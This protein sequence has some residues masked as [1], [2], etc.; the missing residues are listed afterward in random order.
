MS[1]PLIVI[2]SGAPFEGVRR[3]ARGLS[4]SLA[5][6]VKVLFVDPT[7]SP[8]AGSRSVSLRPTLSRPAPNLFHLGAVTVPGHTRMG[9]RSVAKSAVVRGVRSAIS[10]IGVGS[11]TAVF[12]QTPRVNLLGQFDEDISIYWATDS[13]VD[14]FALMGVDR[15]SLA[16]AEMAS[17]AKADLVIAVTESLASLWSEQGKRVA[18]VRNGVDVTMEPTRVSPIPDD[19]TLTRPIAGVVGT[20]SNRLDFGMLGAVSDAGAS[21]LLIG[22]ASFRTDRSA[23]DALCMRPNVLWLGPK[24]HSDLGR[25]YQHMDV[26]LVPYTLSD[27]NRVSAPL[28]PLEYLAAGLPVVSTRLAGV[29]AIDSPDIAFASDSAEFVAATER[30]IEVSNDVGFVARRRRHVLDWSWDRRA[31][32]VLRILS[33]DTIS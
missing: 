12:L 23:F 3:S 15:S 27:F 21:I 1:D 18:V 19:L 2:F 8:F 26:G 10:E 29:V 28:K 32:E 17:V 24:D 11:P 5:C 9:I 22:P 13:F 20:L 25:Y 4:D 30:A 6:R 31:V 14:G 7:A 33:L 16:R